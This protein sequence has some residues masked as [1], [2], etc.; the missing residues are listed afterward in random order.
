MT[1]RP[2]RLNRIVLVLFGLVLMAAGG[3][4]LAR[5]YGALGSSK[6]HE[7]ILIPQVRTFIADHHDWFWWAAGALSVLIALLALAW[8]R[9]QLH[10]PR[11]ANDNL[12]RAEPDGL[13]RIHGSAPA[14]ALAADIN[15]L[16]GVAATAARIW[17]DPTK[18][19]VHL[20]LQLHDDAAL[21]DLRSR[22]ETN[23]LDRLRQALQVEHLETTIDLRLAQPLGRTIH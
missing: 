11:P 1:R 20:Q 9:A 18:P 14:D 2:Y 10:F 5:S 6:Q 17:G 4:G 15:T 3:Y 19:H 22:I 7:P 8:L 21:E 13:T 16:P 12:D 23:H